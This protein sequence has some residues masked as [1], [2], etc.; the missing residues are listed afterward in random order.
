MLLLAEKK[1]IKRLCRKNP[2]VLHDMP[3]RLFPQAKN[4]FAAS[5]ERFKKCL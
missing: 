2:A 3:Q 5:V 1:E 4:K